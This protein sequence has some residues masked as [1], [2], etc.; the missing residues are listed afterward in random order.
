MDE[1]GTPFNDAWKSTSFSTQRTY[2]QTVIISS[3]A[4][5]LLFAVIAISC[6]PY[7]AEECGYGYYQESEPTDMIYE[8]IV[9][10]KVV[11]K[12]TNRTYLDD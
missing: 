9:K 4:C 12:N 11:K 10:S 7:F 2:K 6:L 3:I 8:P 5:I 1:N